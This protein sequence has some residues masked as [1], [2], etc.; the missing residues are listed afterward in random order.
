[1][2]GFKRLSSPQRNSKHRVF[3]LD[4]LSEIIQDATVMEM[5]AKMNDLTERIVRYEAIAKEL[6]QYTL[7]LGIDEIITLDDTQI[8]EKFFLMKK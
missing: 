4:I 1:M 5:R 2:L 7:K 3:L 6:E 8:L